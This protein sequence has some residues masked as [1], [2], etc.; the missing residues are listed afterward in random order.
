MSEEAVGQRG[1]KERMS[2]CACGRMTKDL[3]GD[4]GGAG[5]AVVV[6]PRI[7]PHS[8]PF[9]FFSFFLPKAGPQ[10]EYNIKGRVLFI[11]MGLFYSA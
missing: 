1:W 6:V 11:P 5:R 9:R 10:I 7:P 3:N 4:V 2:K 8:P